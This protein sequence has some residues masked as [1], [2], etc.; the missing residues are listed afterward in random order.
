MGDKCRNTVIFLIVISAVN[1]IH[2]PHQGQTL[3]TDVRYLWGSITVKNNVNSSFTF[4]RQKIIVIGKLFNLPNTNL[5]NR[6]IR[7]FLYRQLV[8]SP[9]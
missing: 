7:I 9:T 2:Q 5:S 3:D 8:C 1:L 6:R 4:C